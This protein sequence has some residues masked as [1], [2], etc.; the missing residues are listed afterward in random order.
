MAIL[1]TIYQGQERWKEA[2]ALELRVIG[3]KQ[4]KLDRKHCETVNMMADLV[5]SYHQQARWAETGQLVL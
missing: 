4:K 1:A 5:V 3:L 2:E